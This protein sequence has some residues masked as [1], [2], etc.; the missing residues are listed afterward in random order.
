MPGVNVFER[1]E[2]VA[3]AE[4]AAPL[5]IMAIAPFKRAARPLLQLGRELGVETFDVGQ[6]FERR[7]RRLPRAR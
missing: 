1:R 3:D 7:R 4:F 6:V 2:V 5:L